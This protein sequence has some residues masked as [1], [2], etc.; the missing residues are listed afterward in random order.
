MSWIVTCWLCRKSKRRTSCGTFEFCRVKLERFTL[1]FRRIVKILILLRFLIRLSQR[2]T[3][4]PD[5]L[6]IVINNLIISYTTIILFL[7]CR[8][9]CR[10]ANLPMVLAFKPSKP[11]L[12]VL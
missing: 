9:L 7:S 10:N 2:N 6:I 3:E 8:C 5:T 12:D 11:M 4:R 1:H